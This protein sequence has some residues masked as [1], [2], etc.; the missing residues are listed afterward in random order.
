MGDR[1]LGHRHGDQPTVVV[2]AVIGAASP[3]AI[4]RKRKYAK[5]DVTYS[6][7]AGKRK[8]GPFPCGASGAAAAA[9][10]GAAPERA[11]ALSADHPAWGPLSGVPF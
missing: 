9:A 6:P 7:G 10:A 3:R 8:I 1:V 2:I 4:G 11:E 5:D